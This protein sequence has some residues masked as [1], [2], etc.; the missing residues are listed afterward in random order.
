M[1]GGSTVLSIVVDGKKPGAMKEPEM[2]RRLDELQRYAERQPEVG[3]TLSLAE[4][5]KRMHLVM[6]ENKEEFH[7]IPDSRDLIAQY[8]LLY[9]MSGDPGDFDEVV[10]YDYRKSSVKVQLKRDNA[11]SIKHF[12]ARME[13]FLE[14]T[15]RASGAEVASTGHSA[16]TVVVVDLVISG[17]LT[18][19]L[20]AFL[21]IFLITA[22]MFRSPL[23]GLITL[24][25]VAGAILANFGLLSAFGIRL[26]IATTMNS[27]IGIGIG[28]DYTIHFMAR[29]REMLKV[30][31][32]PRWAIA[33]TMSSSGKAILFNALVVALGFLVLLFS[34][35]PPNQSLG[36]LVA[37]NMVTSFLGAMTILPAVLTF[38]PPERILAE[39]GLFRLRRMWYSIADCFALPFLTRL[40]DRGVRQSRKISLGGAA[41]IAR[42]RRRIGG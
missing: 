37:L 3:E 15:F 41:G 35:T 13:P 23:I 21:I 28:I 10:D 14:E 8:L 2:L 19:L 9:S 22:C 26:G 40:I 1:M 27:C 32:E 7:A 12:L 20:T 34:V 30:R 24:I 4:Y 25:P 17:L 5:V 38:V 11:L 29:Y 16:V 36:L 6:N 18:S 33:Q 39:V 42:V 31:P